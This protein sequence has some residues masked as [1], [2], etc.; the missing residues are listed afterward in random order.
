[1]KKYFASLIKNKKQLYVFCPYILV[2]LIT[3]LVA[4]YFSRIGV[5]PHHDGIMLKPAID[6][7]RGKILFKETFNQY[8]A[9]TIYLQSLFIKLFG[10]YLLVIKLL[11]AFI[12]SAIA[13]LTY[14]IWTKILPK[15]LAFG[16]ILIWLTVAPFYVLTFLAWSSTQALLFQLLTFIFLMLALKNPSFKKNFLLGICIALTFWSKQN[17]GAYTLLGI[18]AISIIHFKNLKKTFKFLL[19]NFFGFSA[20][21]LIFI[22]VIVYQGATEEWIK[23]T[24]IFTLRWAELVASEYPFLT[25]LFYVSRHPISLWAI[26]PIFSILILLDKK[27]KLK[28]KNYPVIY[29]SIFSLFSW[30]QYH[31]VACV[32]HAFWAATPMIGLLIYYLYFQIIKQNNWRFKYLFFIGSIIFL[33]YPDIKFRIQSAKKMIALNS[34]IVTNESVLKGMKLE[35]SKAKHFRDMQAK[36]KKLQEKNS[37]QKLITIT[38]D[39]L[40]LLLGK[41]ENYQPMYVSWHTIG[42]IYPDFNIIKDQ[43]IKDNQPIII[44]YDFLDIKDY[45]PL[46][47]SVGYDQ[48]VIEIPCTMIEELTLEL[49]P[50]D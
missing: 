35:P 19:D 43:Y 10:E 38:P 4:A 50:L 7:S 40:Y 16:S 6:V 9:L 32:R 28:K 17:V 33:F 21:S 12:Y 42:F 36:I 5:D 30:L 39:A 18:I 41:S 1:M 48:T 45:C 11:T 47:D 34:E 37:E 2:F 3:L 46:D 49:K 15:V 22:S 13:V 20:I 44:S 14:H 27:I 25:N 29:L 31:P 26:L 24:F 23:Q 8:G